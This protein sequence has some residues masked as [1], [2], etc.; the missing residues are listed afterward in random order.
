MEMLQSYERTHRQNYKY[1]WVTFTYAQPF[2]KTCCCVDVQGCMCLPVMP[3]H[4]SNSIPRPIPGH[5]RGLQCLATL[6][7]ESHQSWGVRSS[8]REAGRKIG[9][10]LAWEINIEWLKLKLRQS[11]LDAIKLD[12]RPV[13]AQV[14]RG[15]FFLSQP[16]PVTAFSQTG[17][18]KLF[19][20]GIGYS[21]SDPSEEILSSARQIHLNLN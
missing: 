21:L 17:C 3:P 10:A 4:D 11:D 15:D 2:D 8:A 5:R 9:S 6:S 18:T 19:R 1:R 7:T 13:I 14:E 12:R 20:S 16:N